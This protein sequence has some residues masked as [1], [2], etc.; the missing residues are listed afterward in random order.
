MSPGG[1]NNVLATGLDMGIQRLPPTL[2]NCLET[3][4]T[5]RS[6]SQCRDTE[7]M[8]QPLLRIL[9]II[10]RDRSMSRDPII[11]QRHSFIIPLNPNLQIL[12]FRN[13]LS[14]PISSINHGRAGILRQTTI[15]E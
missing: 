9:D 12:A 7:S 2:P 5:N 4:H 15:S 13:M 8:S 6:L 14:T 3:I 10:I 11:P 1:I